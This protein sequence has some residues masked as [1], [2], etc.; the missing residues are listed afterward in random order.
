VISEPSS[1][2]HRATAR[3]TGALAHEL[4][5]PLQGVLSLLTVL[6]HECSGDKQCQL[7][8]EQIRSGL[9]RMS[10]TVQSFSLTYENLPRPPDCVAVDD[11]AQRL[12]SAMTERQLRL[13][14]EVSGPRDVRC[15]GLVH[16]FVSLLAEAYSQSAVTG[17]T[18]HAHIANH[19]GWVML[20]CEHGTP[21]GAESWVTLD[22]E[23]YISG[24]AVLMDEITK[25]A[26]GRAEFR[27]GA[28]ALNG[29]RLFLRTSMDRS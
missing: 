27:F 16:E 21:D 12:E 6:Q 15:Y 28:A 17:R 1:E 23:E 8:L 3:I 4:N 5:S 24:L 2:D 18:I 7:R 19:D 25:L 10:Q 20:E 14:V 26:G 22:Q 13:E 29:I 11:L 9:S